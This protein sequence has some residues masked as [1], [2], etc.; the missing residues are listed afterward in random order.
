MEGFTT[1]LSA[2]TLNPFKSGAE[3]APSQ[4]RKDL[5]M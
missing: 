1:T 4:H 3:L 5:V 2:A